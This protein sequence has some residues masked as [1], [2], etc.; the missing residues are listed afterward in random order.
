MPQSSN[1][2]TNISS[3]GICVSKYIFCGTVAVNTRNVLAIV[4]PQG[5]EAILVEI[6]QSKQ[7]RTLHAVFSKVNTDTTDQDISLKFSH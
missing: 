2:R 6:L 3:N 5:C 1:S 4:P 7:D